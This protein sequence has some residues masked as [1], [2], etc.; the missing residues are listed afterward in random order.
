MELIKKYQGF[1]AIGLA[2]IGLIALVVLT[3]NNNST[4]T[5]KTANDSKATKQDAKT[6]DK[7]DTSAANKSVNSGAVY[8]YTAQAGDS[9]TVLARKA[10]QTYGINEK[11]KL[12][13]AQIV[14]AETSLTVNA[15]SIDLNEGQTVAIQKSAVKA[16]VDAAKK[17]SGDVL[18]AWEVYVPYVDFNTSTAGQSQTK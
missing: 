1:I 10:V 9:Y 5:N 7:A 14:A 18:A 17:L 3:S 12:S 11:V 15:G 16:A 8:N 13:P 6:T 2:V 4:D